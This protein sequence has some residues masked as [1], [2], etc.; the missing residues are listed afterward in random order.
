VEEIAR[1]W[2][3]IERWLSQHAPETFAELEVGALEAEIAEAE[4]AMYLSR[5][6]EGLRACWA[7]HRSCPL[8]FAGNE[9]Y[10]PKQAVRT[11]RSWVAIAR[12]S[13]GWETERVGPV[14][15]GWYRPAWIPFAGDD[16]ISAL[17]IDLEPDEGGVVGQILSILPTEAR[18]DVIA[19]SFEALLARIADEMEAGLFEEDEG[20]L[21][22]IAEDPW[23]WP[24]VADEVAAAAANPSASTVRQKIPAFDSSGLA[25]GAIVAATLSTWDVRG[26]GLTHGN[27]QLEVW[28]GEID[29]RGHVFT[30]DPAIARI[31]DEVRVKV[32]EY[33][34]EDHLW[35]CSM[36]QVDP[37][38]DPLRDAAAF[39]VGRVH[40]ARV[41]FVEPFRIGVRLRPSGMQAE[42]GRR[43]TEHEGLVAGVELTVQI[44]SVEAS[45]RS[46]RVRIV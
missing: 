30:P 17:A 5:L 35:W 44:E 40:R 29:W 34:P 39:A 41:A 9:L 42:I 46:L 14:R 38:A 36:R 8:L 1:T 32:L 26:M 22:R 24:D 19:T 12:T 6:P 13:A 15:D 31:G 28:S 45:H 16:N 11:W 27:A 43:V 18:R 2:A 20:F 33:R 25:P 7:L 23:T 10:S 37:E 3:R 4:A 21:R